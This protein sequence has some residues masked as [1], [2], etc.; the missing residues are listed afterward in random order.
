MRLKINFDSPPAPTVLHTVVGGSI[1]LLQEFN[2]GS[3]WTLSISFTHAS[4]MR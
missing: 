4:R 2:L 3:E 1:F